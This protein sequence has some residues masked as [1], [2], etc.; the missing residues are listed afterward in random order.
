MV[1]VVIG[2]TEGINDMRRKEMAYMLLALREISNEKFNRVLKNISDSVAM[3]HGGEY[4]CV[5]TISADTKD[6]LKKKV[7]LI[8]EHDNVVYCTILLVG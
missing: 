4:D 2:N 8:R 6:E 1:A 7:R 5:V 3:T